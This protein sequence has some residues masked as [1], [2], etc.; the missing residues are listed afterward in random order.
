MVFGKLFKVVI[1][2]LFLAKFMCLFYCITSFISKS[3][4]LSLIFVYFPPVSLGRSVFAPDIDGKLVYYLIISHC[5]LQ[6]NLLVY[7]IQSDIS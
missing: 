1:I 2:S 6:I 4:H 5:V 7:L 3:L